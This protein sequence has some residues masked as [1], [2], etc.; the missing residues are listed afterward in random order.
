VP[1]Y[2]AKNFS[3]EVLSQCV[4]K[5]FNKTA[6]AIHETFAGLK[7]MPQGFRKYFI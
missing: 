3:F 1:E 2:L 5:I 6:K 4:E 7:I